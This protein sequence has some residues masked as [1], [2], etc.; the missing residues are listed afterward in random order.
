MGKD[1]SDEELMLSYQTG[2]AASFETLYQRHKGGLYRYILRQCKN[3][4]IAEELYQDVWMNLIKARERYE[5]KAKFTTWL[6]QMAHNRLI[7]HYR[8]QKTAVGG[9]PGDAEL[10]VDETPARTQDQPEQKADLMAKT[11]RLLGLIDALPAEQKQAFLLREEAGM[12]I[13]EI[14]EASGVNPET[15]KSRLRYAVNKLREGLSEHGPG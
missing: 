15:A 5:V 13:N 9:N 14:A 10:D 2:D 1:K 7:D 11:D 3:E 6:Y 12:S 4:S 8:R